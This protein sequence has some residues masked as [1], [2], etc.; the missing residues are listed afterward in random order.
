MKRGV[1]VVAIINI[2]SGLKK[3]YEH[4]NYMNLLKMTAEMVQKFRFKKRQR[5]SRFNDHRQTVLYTGNFVF[6]HLANEHRQ[7]TMHN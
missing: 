4:N 5:F 2:N 6:K 7:S 3:H 1:S